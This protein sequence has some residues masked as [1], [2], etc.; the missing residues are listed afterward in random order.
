MNRDRIDM[1]TTTPT[2]S[3]THPAVAD[4]AVI[5]IEHDG[6]AMTALVLLAGDEALI[7]DACDGSTPFVVRYEEL[8]P[9]RVF[10]PELLGLAA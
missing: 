1:T 3:S 9:F 6:E 4:G 2:T 5:E 8:G 7:L 10:E